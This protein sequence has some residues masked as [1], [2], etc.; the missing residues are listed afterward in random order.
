MSTPTPFE[1]EVLQALQDIKSDVSALKSDVS[2]LKSDVSALKSDMVE[3]KG[4]LDRIETWNDKAFSAIEDLRTEVK[5]D[6]AATRGMIYEAYEQIADMRDVIEKRTPI[7]SPTMNRYPRV[8]V[9]R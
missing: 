8:P 2:A 7:Q 6:G 9:T 1:V 4:K 5:S 3:V